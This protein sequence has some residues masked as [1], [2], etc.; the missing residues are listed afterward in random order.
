MIYILPDNVKIVSYKKI[1][2]LQEDE[3]EIISKKHTIILK[4][5]KLFISYLD[6]DEIII[7]G[8]VNNI[9]LNENKSNK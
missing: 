5:D 6:D 9:I 1:V 3:M 8:K 7:S 4:G 2:K